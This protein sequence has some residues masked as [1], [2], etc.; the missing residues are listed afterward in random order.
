MPPSHLC[1]PFRLLLPCDTYRGEFVQLGN[2]ISTSYDAAVL[3]TLT[4]TSSQPTANRAGEL[5]R[6]K[7]FLWQSPHPHSDPSCQLF[8][9]PPTSLTLYFKGILQEYSHLP[10]QIRPQEQD[11]ASRAF[12]DD[13]NSGSRN[14]RGCL[15]PEQGY[16]KGRADRLLR[17]AGSAREEPVH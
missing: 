9:L 1:A 7:R 17:R 3:P 15:S 14:T 13:P 4:L 8:L 2:Y 10:T 12:S 11:S 5:Q 6:H 16:W